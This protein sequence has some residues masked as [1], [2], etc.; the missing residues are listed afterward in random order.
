MKKFLQ[1]FSV[2]LL[3]CISVVAIGIA[4][5]QLA[6]AAA[7]TVLGEGSGVNCRWENT[8]RIICA[9]NKDTLS[10]V[11]F[12]VAGNIIGDKADSFASYSLD[13][14]S[15]AAAGHLVFQVDS[16]PEERDKNTSEYGILHFGN[17]DVFNQATITTSKTD[18]SGGVATNVDRDQ[19]PIENKN[20]DTDRPNVCS[21]SNLKPGCINGFTEDF[22]A[23]N[24]SAATEEQFNTVQVFL[25]SGR[26]SAAKTASC[27]ADAGP[28]GFFLCPLS[29]MITGI[30]TWSLNV[31]TQLLLVPPLSADN[32]SLIDAVDSIRNIANTFYVIIFL[33]IIFANFIAIPGLDNYSVKKLLPKLITVIILT[34]FSYFICS[35]MVDLG[36]IAGQTIPLAIATTVDGDAVATE[37]GLNGWIAQELLNPVADVIDTIEAPTPAKGAA[38]A[39]A[40]ALTG[41]GLYFFGFIIVLVAA[42]IILISLFYLMMRW[43]GIML[44][45]IFAPIAF[46]AWVLPNTEKFAKMWI[47]AFVKLTL[48]YVLV[49]SMLVSATII[50]GIL[51]KTSTEGGS[52]LGP[53]VAIFIPLIAIALVP[54]CLKVSSSML[55]AAGKMAADSKA[56]KA[57]A[58]AAKKSGQEGKLAEL[59]GKGFGA[60]SKMT[61]GKA[62]KGFG[63]Q[64]AATKARVAEAN[65]KLYEGM[66]TERLQ[67]LSAAEL[68]GKNGKAG[69]ATKQLTKNYQKARVDLK[70][71]QDAGL[72]YSAEQQ[73][74]YNQTAAAAGGQDHD[75]TLRA[76]EAAAPQAVYAVPDPKATTGAGGGGGAAPITAP[77]P[78]PGG[79]KRPPPYRGAKPQWQAAPGS[80]GTPP[81]P[82]PAS[83][84]PP[85][86]PSGKIEDKARN[87]AGGQFD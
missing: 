19:V 82:T 30:L 25:E 74:K 41:G 57:G 24:K 11:I 16:K 58:A 14:V 17:N 3:S 78:P 38:A 54:K 39:G 56:G 27:Q 65:S 36:N 4:K 9:E 71:A 81:S 87:I 80:H 1:I 35:A 60:L 34:Q 31:F 83:S 63:N 73:T 33:I 67:K 52:A 49:M 62:G 37:G 18:A 20:E 66:D 50:K 47:T 61:P 55:T 72:T 77:N 86:P 75:T 48:M 84:S 46:A 8:S 6:R 59:K 7:P 40:V 68:A 51:K 22:D 23:K 42:V 5:P 69:P 21:L 85:V 10:D 28:L 13:V 29:D 70:S 15:S 2:L 43:F 44:L 79:G 76:F 53:F 12:G 45:T 26:E 32:K 64:Q